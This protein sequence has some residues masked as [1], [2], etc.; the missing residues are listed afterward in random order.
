MSVA[1]HLQLLICTGSTLSRR[2]SQNTVTPARAHSPTEPQYL[3]KQRRSSRESTRRS[4][5]T[6]PKAEKPVMERI[7]SSSAIDSSSSS[8]EPE[9]PHQV[10]RSR[11]SLRR[12]RYSSAKS[13]LMT[14]SDA[15]E[16]GDEALPFLPFSEAA[17]AT[18]NQSPSQHASVHPVITP[19]SKAKAT[20]LQTVYSSSSSA[21]SQPKNQKRLPNRGLTLSP[22]QR[23]IAREA[24]SDGTP[25][26]GSSFSD[27]DDASV[28]Q[29]AMEEAMA[30]EMQAGGM[31]SRMSTISQALRSTSKYL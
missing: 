6:S 17:V 28:T 15:D 12:P 24:G 4:L 22:Q 29:S 31:A 20:A 14:L 5:D 26:M 18:H 23:R 21:H 2:S 30:G 27:L 7:S 13:N 11:T 9:I 16:D 1:R 19:S 10:S 3:S 25:S 8:S